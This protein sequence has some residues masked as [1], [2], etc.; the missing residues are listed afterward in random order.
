[1]E[2]KTVEL[3]MGSSYEILGN[4]H[5]EVEIPMAPNLRPLSDKILVT[6]NLWSISV[7]SDVDV[8]YFYT[9]FKIITHKIRSLDDVLLFS[10]EAQGVENNS[11]VKKKNSCEFNL[12]KAMLQQY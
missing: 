3:E 5:A 2:G 1:L 10:I 12:L 11:T 4:I 9:R 6:S 8:F 7:S